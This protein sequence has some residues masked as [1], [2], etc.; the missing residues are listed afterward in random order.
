METIMEQRNY[1]RGEILLVITAIIW[2][3]SFV[4]QRL[5]MEYIGPFTFTATRFLIGT[6]SLIPVILLMNKISSKKEKRSTN[7]TKKDLLVGGLLCGIALFFGISF[8]QVGLVYT[9]A[10]KAGFITALYIVLVPLLGLLMR[11]KVS[12]A[13][14]TGV[15]LA[16]VGLYL[17][18]MTEGFTISKGDLIVLCGTVFWAAHILIIDH[19]APK[20][21]GLKMSFIQ[22]LIA[23]IVSFIVALFV[24]TIEFSAILA[25]AGPLLYTGIVV[26]GV[27]YTFQI[28]GQKGTKPTVSAI[29]LSMESVF[30]VLSGMLLLGEVMSVKEVIGC[31]FMFAAVI[32]AQVKLE[33]G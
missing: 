24:E 9:T 1:I 2:G 23:G 30:A 7:R 31:I 5:G 28:L 15:V 21:D 22:F 19:F 32:M 3:T 11:Q 26:V 29:I 13:V 17:L 10:G 4:A 14:W 18:C 8:Q 33:K 20:V 12:R 6:L 25:S 16:V 27:A